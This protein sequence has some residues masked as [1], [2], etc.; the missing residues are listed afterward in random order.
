MWRGRLAVDWGYMWNVRDGKHTL[1]VEITIHN[2]TSSIFDFKTVEILSPAAVI[3]RGGRDKDASWAPNIVPIFMQ[4][5]PKK[6]AKATIHVSFDWHALLSS[7]RRIF[8]SQRVV[9]LPIQTLI[10][11]RSSRRQHRRFTSHIPIVRAM[12]EKNATATIA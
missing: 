6:S 9:K 7:K 12:I 2:E 1:E 10:A 8:S 4:V 5:E 11:S 3:T